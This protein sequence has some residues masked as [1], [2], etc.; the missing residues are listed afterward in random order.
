MDIRMPVMDGVEA[1]RK[2][3]ILPGGEHATI[4]G[5]TTYAFVH[6]KENILSA[7]LND[8]I[9]KPFEGE[10]LL[11]SVESY[12]QGAAGRESVAAGGERATGEGVDRC[13]E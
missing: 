12:L 1:T 6:D 10:K 4:I 13:M 5:L 9:S 11:Q 8:V 2:I 7:G 3:R